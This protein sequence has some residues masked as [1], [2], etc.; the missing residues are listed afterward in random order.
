MLDQC[1]LIQN[2][3]QLDLFPLYLTHFCE[4]YSKYWFGSISLLT[5]TSHANGID[6]D[7]NINIILIFVTETTLFVATGRTQCTKKESF[8][9]LLFAMCDKTLSLIWH[10]HAAIFQTQMINCIDSNMYIQAM[11]ITH[12]GFRA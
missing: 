12:K 11:K 6:I 3:Q 8:V 4:D 9:H 7:D 2:T 5:L 10:S 1:S